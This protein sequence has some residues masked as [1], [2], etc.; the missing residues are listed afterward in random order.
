MLPLIFA[1]SA[2]TSPSNTTLIT[3]FNTSSF[4]ALFAQNPP[5]RA[6]SCIIITFLHIPIGRCSCSSTAGLI[7]LFLFI[8]EFDMYYQTILTFVEIN[9]S[10]L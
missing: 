3:T 2:T 7:G 4:S 10:H 6:P 5:F 8:I 9:N 1:D